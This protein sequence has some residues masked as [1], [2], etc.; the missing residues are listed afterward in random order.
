MARKPGCGYQSPQ[1]SAPMPSPHEIGNCLTPS[2]HPII[3][4]TLPLH[5]G[6]SLL[7]VLNGLRLLS[8][9]KAAA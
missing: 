7:V 5:T 2:L 3:T 6:A 8:G 1:H 4:T 9:G